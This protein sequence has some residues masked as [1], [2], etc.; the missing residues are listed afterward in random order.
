MLKLQADQVVQRRE[1][2]KRIN[3]KF[4]NTTSLKSSDK[5]EEDDVNSEEAR[6]MEEDYIEQFL[7]DKQLQ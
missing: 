3:S 4:R 6:Q 1:T 2:A 7:M 5:R